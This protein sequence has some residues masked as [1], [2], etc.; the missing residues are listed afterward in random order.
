MS[1][2]QPASINLSEVGK[3]GAGGTEA[4][5]L[6]LDDADESASPSALIQAAAFCL[7]VCAAEA[8]TVIS[9]VG[10][11]TNTSLHVYE[12]ISS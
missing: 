9:Y 8:N 6:S 3:P 10:A 5:C 12:T 2:F 1:F 7:H 4:A 11:S